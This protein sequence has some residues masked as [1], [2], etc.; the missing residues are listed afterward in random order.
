MRS[1]KT[2]WVKMKDNME[3]KFKLNK[4]NFKLGLT[5]DYAIRYGMVFQFGI[6]KLT[7]WP[8]QGEAFSRK[9]YRGFWIRKVFNGFMINL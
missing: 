8:P 6:F 2:R 9:Y 7:G 1:L 3:T 4:W 5:P